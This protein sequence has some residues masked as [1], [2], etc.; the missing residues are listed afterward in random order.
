VSELAG[1]ERWRLL[2]PEAA[3]DQLYTPIRPR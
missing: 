1:L 2:K 3:A